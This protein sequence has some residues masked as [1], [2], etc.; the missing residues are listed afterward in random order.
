MRRVNVLE[1]NAVSFHDARDA[2]VVTCGLLRHLT[3]CGAVPD[4][5]DPAGCLL[6]L[7]LQL[8]KGVAPSAFNDSEVQ[9]SG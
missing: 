7:F 4:E 5:S 6:N 1:S 3:S 2:G 8:P 9:R